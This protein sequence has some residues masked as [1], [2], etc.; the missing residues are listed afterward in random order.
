[1]PFFSLVVSTKGRSHELRTLL[2]SLAR[3]SFLDFEFLLIDQNAGNELEGLA[4]EDWGFEVT[5]IRRPFEQG[6]SRGRNVGL[7]ASS[8]EYVCFPDDDCW[9]GS[10]FLAFGAKQIALTGADV[11]T[12]RAANEEGQSINGRFAAAATWV[13]SPLQVW[14]TQIEWVAFFRRSLLLQLDGYDEDVGI[15]ASTPWQACEGQEVVLRALSVGAKCYYDPALTGQH[16]EI[17]VDQPSASARRKA[18]GYARGMG[19]VLRK[20][21]FGS[22]A[23][24]YWVLRPLVRSGLMLALFKPTD[25]RYYVTVAIGRLEGALGR[26]S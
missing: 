26:P 19:Y 6:L 14:T 3:Q 20:H 23:V 8:G 12:G 24:L 18:L 25:A 7:R 13:T 2:E 21:R 9:Y 11:L 5:R 15:G 1:M 22:P 4:K 10:E 16:A 17:V